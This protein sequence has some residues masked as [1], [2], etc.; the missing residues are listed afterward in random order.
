MYVGFS[1]GDTP[2][3]S[4]IPL[5]QCSIAAF[6]LMPLKCSGVSIKGPSREPTIHGHL[7][8]S[9]AVSAPPTPGTSC[10]ARPG[11]PLLVCCASEICS[12][13]LGALFLYIIGLS[14]HQQY[15]TKG[16][17]WAFIDFSC[18]MFSHLSMS[19]VFTS[20]PCILLLFKQSMFYY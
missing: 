7:P 11:C 15:L 12:H 6:V 10:P 4:C 18:I 9:E 13:L 5:V 20:A 3:T 2:L 1:R 14:R 19:S 16:W 17:P 8:P